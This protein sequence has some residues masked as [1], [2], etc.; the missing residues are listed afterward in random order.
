MRRWNG[1]LVLAVLFVLLT[2]SPAQAWWRGGCSGG[3]CGVPSGSVASRP[4]AGRW[5]TPVRNVRFL[6]GR[7]AERRAAGGLPRQRVFRR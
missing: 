3:S 1:I 4:S 6:A 7:R 5:Y 2:I